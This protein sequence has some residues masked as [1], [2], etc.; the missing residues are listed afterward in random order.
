MHESNKNILKMT[1]PN[2]SKHR[3]YKTTMNAHVP[4]RK[5]KKRIKNCFLK[6][7]I[8]TEFSS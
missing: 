3:Q 2:S 4:E 1:Y 5:T 6:K 7:I 8:K